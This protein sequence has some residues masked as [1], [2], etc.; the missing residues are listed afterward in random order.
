M[1]TLPSIEPTTKEIDAFRLAIG[2]STLRKLSPEQTI[3][4]LKFV[5]VL[6][7]TA[8]ISAILT[9]KIQDDWRIFRDKPR[10]PLWKCIDRIVKR[11]FAHVHG[12]QKIV[13]KWDKKKKAKARAAK[14]PFVFALPDDGS[15][16]CGPAPQTAKATDTPMKISLSMSP[17]EIQAADGIQLKPTDD[18]GPTINPITEQEKLLDK[19]WNEFE[20]WSLKSRADEQPSPVVVKYL[21]TI[22]KT[23]KDI[24]DMHQK[25]KPPT[26]SNGVVGD[27]APSTHI[28]N[29][30]VI[31]EKAVSNSDKV[32]SVL[33]DLTTQL[34]TIATRPA[35][36]SAQSPK[37]QSPD[38][39]N[40]S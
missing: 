34:E 8:D 20:Y 35:I 27:G 36:T 32:G 6:E 13:K 21:E 30:Q 1:T 26:S 15:R 11:Y 31:F 18:T 29:M 33:S 17:E 4:L 38:T 3:D 23:I 19:L 12:E 39:Q 40:E 9:C 10:K 2:S 25:L 5:K 16:L 14:K 37:S 7:G 22:G 28:E 24:F